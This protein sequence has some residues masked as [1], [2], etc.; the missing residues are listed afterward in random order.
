MNW[1]HKDIW[2]KRED[3]FLIEIS[4]HEVDYK[5]KDKGSSRW[6]IYIYIYPGYFLFEKILKEG[7]HSDIINDMPLHGGESYFQKHINEKGEITSIQI[8]AD[9]DHLHDD[10]YSFYNTKENASSVFADADNLFNWAKIN[11]KEKESI[12]FYDI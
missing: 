5:E 1:D 4:R 3:K 6:C 9:Y 7:R 8:G 10:R 2:R 11:N 12:V